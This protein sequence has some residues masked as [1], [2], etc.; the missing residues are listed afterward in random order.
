MR[1]I[2]TIGIVA[3]RHKPETSPIVQEVIDWLRARQIEIILDDE[4]VPLLKRTGM[5]TADRAQLSGL[6]DLIAV[7]GGDGTLL[8]VARVAGGHHPLLF[9]VNLGSLGFLTEI[10]L[11]D[12]YRVL[13]DT[14]NGNYT[15][16]NRQ[17]LV[18]S[19]VR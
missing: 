2:K 4:L 15:I 6:V 19:V 18:A 14:L 16:D 9:G 1:K 11:E 10:S 3:K 12:L 13:E 17:M 7:F 8:S 5:R